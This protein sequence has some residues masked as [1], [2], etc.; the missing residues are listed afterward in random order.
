MTHFLALPRNSALSQDWAH[1]CK[2]DKAKGGGIHYQLSHHP[3]SCHLFSSSSVQ[4]PTQFCNYDLWMKHYFPPEGKKLLLTETLNKGMYGTL[5]YISIRRHV[6]VLE[7]LQDQMA[8]ICMWGDKRGSSL[9]SCLLYLTLQTRGIFA[10][11]WFFAPLRVVP[12]STHIDQPIYPPKKQKW[13]HEFIFSCFS[14]FFMFKIHV[15]SKQVDGRFACFSV[16][17]VTLSQTTCTFYGLNSAS[18]K[19]IHPAHGVVTLTAAAPRYA[20]MYFLLAHLSQEVR[21]SCARARCRSSKARRQRETTV[22]FS[23]FW[24]QISLKY[25]TA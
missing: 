19:S 2:S 20:Q 18:E 22:T 25:C 15:L 24:Q 21:E 8:N 23:T 11:G 5:N 12:G 6:H 1:R 13:D 17:R 10:S 16:A 7:I 14:C 9:R 4:A 3:Q